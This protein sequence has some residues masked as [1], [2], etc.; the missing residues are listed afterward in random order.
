MGWKQPTWMVV[1]E[2]LKSMFNDVKV[3]NMGEYVGDTV[4]YL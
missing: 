1:F 3:V 2:D 4:I